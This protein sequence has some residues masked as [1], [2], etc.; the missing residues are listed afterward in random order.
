MAIFRTML[1]ASSLFAGLLIILSSFNARADNKDQSRET[2]ASNQLHSVGNINQDRAS[3]NVMFTPG[4]AVSISTYPDTASFLNGV[5]PIDDRGYVELPILGKTRISQMNHDDLVNFLL[6]KYR[7]YL[8]FPNIQVKPMIR[9]S[10]LGGVQRP[11]F[12]YFDSDYSLWEVLHLVGG[13]LDEDGLKQMRWERDGNTLEKDLIPYLQSG[14]AL[15]NIRFRSGDQIWVRSPNKPGF[16]TKARSFLN[17][18]TAV[19][20][21]L[22]LYITY[23]RVIVDRRR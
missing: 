3:L 21:F 18:V 16:F 8:R 5:F 2:L 4:D 19:A 13:T 23:Q 11:G 7:D 14:V 12:Y 17:L 6:D 9:L 20:S 22:T 15:K 1:G 10:V